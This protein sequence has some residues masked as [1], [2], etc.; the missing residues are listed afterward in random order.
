MRLSK[1][2]AKAI[3]SVAFAS[4]FITFLISIIFQFNNFQKEVT[5]LKDDYVKLKKEEVKREINKVYFSI[6]QKEKEIIQNI[7][8]LLKDRVN[9]AHS[10]ALSIYEDNKNIKSEEEIKYLIVSALKNISFYKTRSYYFINTNDGKAIL[11]NKQSKLGQNSDV[12]NL[13]DKTG[14]FFIQE[15]AKIALDKNEGFLKTHFVKPDLN[16]NIQYPKLSF[17]KKFEPY[18]WHIGMGEYIDDLTEETKHIILDEIAKIRFGKDGY[19]F[20]NSLNKK[21]LIFDGKRLETPKDYKNEELFNL[22]VEAI[23]NNEGDFIFYKFKKLNSS[24]E[25]PKLAFVR[26]YKKWGWIIG[27][28]IYIDEIDYEVQKRDDI[29]QNTIIKQVVVLF[30]VTSILVAIIYLLS[31]KMSNYLSINIDNLIK[32]FKY[33]SENYKKIDTR[34]LTYEEFEELADSL[35]K[36]LKSRNDTMFKLQNYINIV[37]E[38]VIISSTDDKGMITDASEAFCKVS[39]YSKAELIGS[40]H[41][42]VRH[43]DMSDDF[44]KNMWDT[45]SNGKT[46]IGEIKNKNKKGEEYWVSTIIQP[47]IKHKKII[48]YTAIRQDITDKKRVEYLSITDELTNLYNRR[49]FNEVINKEINRAKRDKHYLSFLMLDIDYFKKYNDNY[50]HQAGDEAL[51]KVAMVLNQNTKRASDF[52]FRL[53]GE[54]FGIIISSTSKDEALTL[55]NKI[56]V[57]IEDLKIPHELSEVSKYL[58]TSIGLVTKEGE[59][60]SNANILYKKA[61]EKLYQAKS[62]GKNTICIDV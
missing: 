13:K 43:E 36:T 58:T 11:F 50:G 2:T 8:R 35:N 49:Y 1:T 52:A 18:N 45:I 42:I 32:S 48:G 55:A 12:W 21:A 28:G 56:K 26:E 59:D 23:K 29:Y 47:E 60:I 9:I 33:A 40:S 17:I 37:N 25:Y 22:Q 15:Q 51:K 27:S 24:K 10:I 41:N 38:N 30:I 20:V 3:F 16:D 44:F 54:E 53:G 7:R 39:G 31:V 34:K 14:K 6:E 46:W 4:I 5:H 19:V 57:C 62:E 61:D